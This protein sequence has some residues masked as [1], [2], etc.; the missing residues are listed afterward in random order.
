MDLVDLTTTGLLT[1][2]AALDSA[3]DAGKRATLAQAAL[4]AVEELIRMGGGSLGLEK[5]QALQAALR[6]ELLQ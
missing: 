4:A 6:A 3:E 5:L 1:D 2:L